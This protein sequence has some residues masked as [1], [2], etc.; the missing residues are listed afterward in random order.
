MTLEQQRTVIAE[1]I[2]SVTIDRATTQGPRFD[3]A[4]IRKPIPRRA[5]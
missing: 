5:A 1:L 3:G 4:R 2:D